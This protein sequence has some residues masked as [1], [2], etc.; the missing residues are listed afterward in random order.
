MLFLGCSDPLPE[1]KNNNLNNLSSKDTINPITEE[2]NSDTLKVRNK[3]S[4]FFL[5]DLDLK[6]V[7]KLI[8]R[9]S[10]QP[11]DNYVTLAILDSITSKTPVTRKFY[12]NSF[13]KILIKSDGALSEACG[14]HALSFFH[15]YPDELKDVF[16]ECYNNPKQCKALNRYSESIAYELLL[17]DNHDD[18]REILFLKLEKRYPEW[19][20]DSIVTHVLNT[21]DDVIYHYTD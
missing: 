5:Y 4:Y 13:K 14:A 1:T 3:N 16:S 17:S 9:D 8:E 20:K 7:A 12:F 19:F 10:I 2:N 21:V 15:N 18:G 11:S 6:E